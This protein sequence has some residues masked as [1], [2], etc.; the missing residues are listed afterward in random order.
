MRLIQF[1][2]ENKNKIA[3]EWVEYAKQNIEAT[4]E[5]N[6]AEVKDH[7]IEMLESII[8]N[9]EVE[10]SNSEQEAKSK[11]NKN[12]KDLHETAAKAHGAQRVKMGFSTVELSSEFRALRA[13]VLRLWEKWDSKKEKTEL[14][15]IIRFN[16]AIDEAWMHSLEKFDNVVDESKNWY[17]SVLGHDLRSPLAAI[18][19]GQQV[20]ALSDQLTEKDKRILRR[21]EASA[22][23]MKELIDNLLELTNVQFGKGLGITRTSVDLSRQGEETIQ[24][25]QLAYPESEFIF[26]SPGPV[27]G[28]WDSLRLKQALTNLIANALKHGKAGGPVTLQ[29]GTEGKNAFFAVHNEG[30]TIPKNEQKLIF[31][32]RY[33]RY[34]QRTGNESS[35]G[36]G[37]FIVREIVKEHN[38]KIDLESTP[39]KGTTFTVFLPRSTDKKKAKQ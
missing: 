14:Y 3:D 1:I 34:S 8:K 10:E 32:D 11:G 39:K 4:R 26:K 36:L 24:E 37:L 31:Q 6:L 16:E 33:L 29:I 17:L 19:G 27:Q 22:K 2:K 28:E 13:S 23:S 15:D 18:L 20:L 7:I 30:N 35:F 9:M 12:S 5:K 25:F 21:T 38:G